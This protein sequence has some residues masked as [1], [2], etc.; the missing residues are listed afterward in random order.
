MK[1]R[2][3]LFFSYLIILFIGCSKNY[4]I[5]SNKNEPVLRVALKH[6]VKDTFITSTGEYKIS[7]QTGELILT[8]DDTCFIYSLGSSPQVYINRSKKIMIKNYPLKFI[9]LQRKNFI[10]YE[11]MVYRG[12]IQ[13]IKDVDGFILPI[14]IVYLEDYLKGVVPSEIGKLDKKRFEA[15]K[16]Q[17]VAART[18]AIK[19]LNRYYDMGYDL[20]ST[21]SDQVYRGVLVE[22]TLVNL[23]VEFT[24]GEIITYKD[25]PIEAKYHSTCGGYTSNNEDEWGGTPQPYLR[26]VKDSPGGCLWISSK[27]YC[28]DSKHFLWTYQ[29]ERGTFY[30]IVSKNASN[31]FNADLDV[32]KF[33]INKKDKH[34]RV[35][36]VELKTKDG[37][38]YYVKGLNIRKL[39]TFEEYYGGFLKSRLFE[40]KEDKEKIVISGKGFGHGVG[41]CQYGAMEMA[42]RGKNYKEILKHYYRGTKLKKLY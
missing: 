10:I 29:F 32:V 9:P 11:G 26:S 5:E 20:E 6:K 17:A 15:L 37:K 42:K 18:Y 4:N 25:K 34:K 8:P 22:D 3:F 24:K 21:I 12:Q 2:F 38:K 1:K 36:E 16:A 30:K 41:M 19:N 39:I 14:N 23:A 7:T 27:P 35:V 13:I 40:I 33:K 28:K 31:I